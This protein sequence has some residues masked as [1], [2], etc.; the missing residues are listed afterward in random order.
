M[1]TKKSGQNAGFE[2]RGALVP[3]P[4]SDER[5][6]HSIRVSAVRKGS[7]LSLHYEVIGDVS[8][9]A[10]PSPCEPR[11]ADGLWEHTCFEAFVSDGDAYY[12][13]NFSP[14]GEWA[15]IARPDAKAPQAQFR[16]VCKK[17]PKPT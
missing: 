9:M 3:H 8:R 7:T 11:R 10:L 12:E 1:N 15:S 14:A 17:R 4:A 2:W 13:F 6:I 5:C 16:R